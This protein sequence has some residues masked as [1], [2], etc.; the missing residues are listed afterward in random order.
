MTGRHQPRD[1]L[2]A[3]LA[4]LRGALGTLNDLMFLSYTGGGSV[5]VFADA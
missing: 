2:A 3:L 4:V 1:E 5:A